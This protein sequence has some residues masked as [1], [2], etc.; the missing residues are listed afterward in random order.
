MKK[1]PFYSYIDTRTLIVFGILHI[2]LA[3]LCFYGYIVY[4]I[5]RSVSQYRRYAKLVACFIVIIL[6]D[7][8]ANFI[9]FVV[10]KDDFLTWCKH[11]SMN[12]MMNQTLQQESLM[13]TTLTDQFIIMNP[14]LVFNCSKLHKADIKF[15]AATILFIIILYIH[16][17]TFIISD[18]KNFIIMQ[19]EIFSQ[20]LSSSTDTEVERFNNYS[21]QN[22][23]ASIELSNIRPSSENN[24]F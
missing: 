2:L 11:K 1:S 13:N 10:K 3:L 9:T 20:P 16:W 21:L 5:K 7:I 17:S 18:S 23:Q 8:I 14:D 22:R 15:S 4:W 19:P 12:T 24:A 6:I